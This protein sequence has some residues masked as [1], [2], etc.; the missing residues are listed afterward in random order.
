MRTFNKFNIIVCAIVLGFC[1]SS[2]AALSDVEY[3][4]FSGWDDS[5]IQGGGQTFTDVCGDI[6][7]TV[8]SL[9]SFTSTSAIGTNVTT[10]QATPDQATLK[11]AFSQPLA[12]LVVATKTVDP[13][14]THYIYGLGA[15]NYVH[16]T[17]TA[18]TVSPAG[19]GTG[20]SITGNAFGVGPGGSSFGETTVAGPTSVLTLTYA[21][22]QDDKFGQWMIGKV[23]P[24]PNSIALLGIGGLGML[25]QGRKRRRR[26]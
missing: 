7:V 25:L 4:D 20:I 1:T 5:L 21:S 10:H 17:G 9:G 24:E 13:E 18:P 2:F 22:L 15:E 11:F 16:D 3:M 6:D 12:N 19:G 14:E 23:V 26:A 8:T